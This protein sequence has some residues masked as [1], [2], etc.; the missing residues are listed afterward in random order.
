MTCFA[1]APIRHAHRSGR[2][3]AEL[4]V[5]IDS[6]SGLMLSQATVTTRGIRRSMKSVPVDSSSCQK[7]KTMVTKFVKILQSLWGTPDNPFKLLG[8]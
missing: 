6:I 2:A 5:T 4:I 7:L 8:N 3:G 1:P